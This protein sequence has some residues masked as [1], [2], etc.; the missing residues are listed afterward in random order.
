MEIHGSD[1]VADCL[2]RYDLLRAGSMAPQASTE[3]IRAGME[4]L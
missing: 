1:E 3:M 2:T 4:E